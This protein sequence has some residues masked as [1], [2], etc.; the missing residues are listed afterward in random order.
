MRKSKSRISHG[1]KPVEFADAVTADHTIINEEDQPRF[2]DQVG[3]VI[4]DRATGWEQSYPSKGHT[5]EETIR[6][7]QQFLGTLKAKNV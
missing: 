2:E 6:A 4:I 5:A 3:F 1:P 7:F